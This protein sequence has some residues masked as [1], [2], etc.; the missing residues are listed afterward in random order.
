MRRGL[1]LQRRFCQ[2]AKE[3]EPRWKRCVQATDRA[4]GD[5]SA[6]LYV[7]KTFG[8]DGKARM[9]KMIEALTA[10]LR[11]DIERSPG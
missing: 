8:A 10:A 4:L 5:A 3:I 6:E 1:P 2:G 11:E 7:E 9:R